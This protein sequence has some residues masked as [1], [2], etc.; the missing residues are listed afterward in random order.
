MPQSSKDGK[1]I[2]TALAL[3]PEWIVVQYHNSDNMMS[4]WLIMTGQKM[5]NYQKGTCLDL[6]KKMVI[7]VAASL[8][9]IV[10]AHMS[11]GPD[12][13]KHRHSFRHD[14]SPVFL[15]HQRYQTQS[16]IFLC[17]KAES[18]DDLNGVSGTKAS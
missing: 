4:L 14:K 3:L 17:K 11:T 12:Q 9:L 6:S 13:E 18:Q 16:A 1:I 5:V 2:F 8:A 15:A 7:T 10:N